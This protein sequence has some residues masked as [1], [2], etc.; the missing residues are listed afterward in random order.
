M[1][2]A[3]LVLLFACETDKRE[4]NSPPSS[5]QNEIEQTETQEETGVETETETEEATDTETEETVETVDP[6]ENF[7]EHACSL[8]AVDAPTIQLAKTESE[9]GQ[10]LILPSSAEG[11]WF[12]REEGQEGW[13]TIE[14]ADW[15]E[16]LHL[17][18][19]PDIGFEVIGSDVIEERANE[20]CPDELQ[21]QFITF[22]EW[23]S[24]VVHFDGNGPATFWFSLVKQ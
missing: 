8:Q 24:Y 1:K 4:S 19:N 13:M 9:A 3:V 18:T 7:E 14:V 6:I 5:A 21:Y 11:F 15:M 2:Y 17:N 20:S 23:G 10:V 22:H 16:L 12:Q